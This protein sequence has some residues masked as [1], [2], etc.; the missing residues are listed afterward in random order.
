[1]TIEKIVTFITMF[2]F[3]SPDPQ[4][5]KET[6]DN[7]ELSFYSSLILDEDTILDEGDYTC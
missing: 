5:F 2:L 1:M 3:I 6:I 4:L 7:K